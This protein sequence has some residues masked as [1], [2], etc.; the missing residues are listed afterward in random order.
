M[1]YLTLHRVEGPTEAPLLGLER[2]QHIQRLDIRGIESQRFA[3]V[4]FAFLDLAFGLWRR[5]C[6]RISQFLAR[7]SA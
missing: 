1:L 2:R 4:R 7:H 5:I 6:S 3:K